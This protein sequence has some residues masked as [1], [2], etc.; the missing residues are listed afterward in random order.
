MMSDEEVSDGEFTLTDSTPQAACFLRIVVSIL[1]SRIVK[2]FA[3]LLRC[4]VSDEPGQ[5]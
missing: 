1:D 2:K 5:G 4:T 3:K